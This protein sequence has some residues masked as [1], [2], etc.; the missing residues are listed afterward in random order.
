MPNL[1]FFVC[2]AQV[3]SS[4]S[5][6]LGRTLLPCE[7]NCLGQLTPSFQ[8][9]QSKQFLLLI[10]HKIAAEAKNHKEAKDAFRNLFIEV[11]EAFNLRF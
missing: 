5:V 7:Q 11:K 2:L 3:L 8:S 10:P 6:Q 4:A 1:P 9:P